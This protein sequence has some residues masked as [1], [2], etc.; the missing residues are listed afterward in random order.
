MGPELKSEG[1]IFKA[2][3]EAVISG[4][5]TDE[6]GDPLRRAQVRLF[7]DQERLG[8]QSMVQHQLVM[9]DDRGI[10]EI[11]NIGPGNYYLAVS[12]QPWYAQRT[13]Y[14]AR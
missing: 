2:T 3:P 11:P 14:A 4:V 5:V 9:T 8:L 12:A 6:G 10:Y 13:A 1:L 7:K